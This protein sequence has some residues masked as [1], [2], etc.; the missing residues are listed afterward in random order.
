[1]MKGRKSLRDSQPPSPG[2]TDDEANSP[3]SNDEDA[4]SPIEGVIRGRQKAGA[5]FLKEE[6]KRDPFDVVH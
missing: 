3:T 4:K 6:L 1:M 2:G 5:K